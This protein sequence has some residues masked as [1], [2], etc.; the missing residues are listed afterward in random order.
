MRERPTTITVLEAIRRMHGEG[1]EA[2]RT[3]LAEA[4]G[5]H[6]TTIDDRLQLLVNEGEVGRA[7]RGVYVPTG[8]PAARAVSVS[9][10]P[11]GIA[12]VTMGETKLALTPREVRMLGEALSGVAGAI[13]GL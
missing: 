7:S 2:T 10:N 3:T 12:V 6:L 11:D 5:L 1:R 4:T 9:L 8:F 13:R